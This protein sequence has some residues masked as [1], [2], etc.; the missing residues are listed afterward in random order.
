MLSNIDRTTPLGRRD[1][2]ILQLLYTYGVRAQQ[3]SLL[4]LDDIKWSAGEI[5]FHAVKGGKSIIVPITDEVGESLYEY[6]QGGRMSSFLPDVFLTVRPP[7]RPMIST[8]ISVLV[9][10]RLQNAGIRLSPHGA[11]VFRHGFASRM[12]GAGYSLKSIADMLGHRDI[13]TTAIYAKVDFRMLAS[14]A[15]EWPEEQP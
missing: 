4:R 11:G 14:V 8:S 15:L 12:L 10:R 7:G 5:R 3:V 2:A 1:Y 13:Q 9:G 6:M